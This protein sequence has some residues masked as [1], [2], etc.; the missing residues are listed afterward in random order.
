MFVFP[1]LRVGAKVTAPVKAAAKESF[2]Y[3]FRV[4][5]VKAGISE[6]PSCLNHDHTSGEPFKHDIHILLLRLLPSFLSILLPLYVALQLIL[7]M[8]NSHPQ[9]Y[10]SALLYC[11]YIAL[12]S[13]WATRSLVDP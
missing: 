8:I 4:T 7:L 5:P 13:F 11:E 6:S 3:F 2:R 10:S 12:M 1:V 9:H